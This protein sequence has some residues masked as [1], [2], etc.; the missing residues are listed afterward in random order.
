MEQYQ[1]IFDRGD[2]KGSDRS[3][4]NIAGT[5]K[6]ADTPKHHRCQGR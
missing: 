6:H 1:A 4:K 3:A 5:T 2:G